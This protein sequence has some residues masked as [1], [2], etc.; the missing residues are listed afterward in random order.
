MLLLRSPSFS[1]NKFYASRKSFHYCFSLDS[2]PQNSSKQ[3]HRLKWTWSMEKKME[4]GNEK[5]PKGGYQ[6]K[7]KEILFLLIDN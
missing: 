5:T 3:W 6:S 2:Y 4:L 1:L 7:R